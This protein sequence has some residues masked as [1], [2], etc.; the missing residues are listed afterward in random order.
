MVE[1]KRA[2]FVGCW[3]LPMQVILIVSPTLRRLSILAS[4][5]SWVWLALVRALNI[6]NTG[7]TFTNRQGRQ[8][9]QMDW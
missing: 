7:M 9:K 5:M 1:Q 6:M 4:M 8:H 2:L 3:S